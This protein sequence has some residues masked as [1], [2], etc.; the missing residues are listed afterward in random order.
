MKKSSA[1]E[2]GFKAGSQTT[3]EAKLPMFLAN[4]LTKLKGGYGALSSGAARG[5]GIGRAQ[6]DTLGHLAQ[7]N[8][9]GLAQN[10]AKHRGLVSGA[11]PKGV[12]GNLGA[13][14]GYAVGK[15]PVATPAAVIGGTSLMGQGRESGRNREQ[16][17]QLK[18][19]IAKLMSRGGKQQSAT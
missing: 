14:G 9:R 16:L 12:L 13:L 17:D 1:Y 19:Q 11:P 3:K 18:Q 6:L 2:L 7:G 8:A 15:H 5:H 4:L 10:I